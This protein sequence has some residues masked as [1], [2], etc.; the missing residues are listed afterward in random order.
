MKCTFACSARMHGFHA[1][2]KKVRFTAAGLRCHQNLK[3]EHVTLLFGP[4]HKKKLQQKACCTCTTIIFLQP[5]KSLSCGVVVTVAVA[6]VI[7]ELKH[8]TFLGRRRRL[9][10]S[11]PG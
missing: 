3:Y 10:T 4:L 8:Q 1:R 5:I 6:V 9:Q 7:R 11:E 2:A